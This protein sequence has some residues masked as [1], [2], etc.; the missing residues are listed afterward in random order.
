MSKKYKNE[1]LS[2]LPKGSVI[3]TSS[4]RRTAQLARN[5]PHLK[6]ENIRGNLNTRLRKL[7]DENG[8]FAAII[9]AVAGLKRLNWENRINQV[10]FTTVLYE[11]IIILFFII[12]RNYNNFII[13]IFAFFITFYSDRYWNQ[14]KH[15]MLL[16]KVH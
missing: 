11:I 15:C 12:Y 7:D 9:L 14:K 13:K 8:P 2:T 3:G 1:T 10:S 4:L 16:D 6:V 5:M